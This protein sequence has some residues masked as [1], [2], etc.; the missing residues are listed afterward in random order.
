MNIKELKL[1]KLQIIILIILI[2]GLVVGLILSQRKQILKSKAD[3]QI[4]NNLQVTGANCSSPEEGTSNCQKDQENSKVTIN[5]IQ[6]LRDLP[7]P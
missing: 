5:G 2:V 7:P 4:Y 3:E 1:S 6:R